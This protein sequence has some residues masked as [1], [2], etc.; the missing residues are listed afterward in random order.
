[1]GC[2]LA[3]LGVRTRGG[4]PELITRGA[5]T[6]I[7][8]R[9]GVGALVVERDYLLTHVI[10]A[11]ARSDPPDSLV[12]KGGTALRLCYFTDFRYSADLDFSVSADSLEQANDALRR[13]AA[14]CC[15]EHG[16]PNVDVSVAERHIDY[17]GPLGRSRR[18]LV[19]LATDELVIETARPSLVRRYA[20]QTDPAPAVLA[21]SLDEVAAEKLR[22]VLQRLQCR[23]LFDLHR[24]L[25]EEEL[26]VDVVWE[27]FERKTVHKGFDPT[28]FPEKLNDRMPQYERRWSDELRTHLG[29]VPDFQRMVRELRRALRSH[30]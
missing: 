10:D 18:L 23:D 1:M 24:L 29:L 9:D 11:L 28:R 4:G 17:V 19:D 6:H 27:L 7:A 20:D 13:A 30:L 5:I 3:L 15:A 21:Y 25:V 26:E 14:L 22:C 2:R 16:F 12:F 8:D